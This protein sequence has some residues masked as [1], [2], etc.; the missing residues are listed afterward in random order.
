MVL[1]ADALNLLSQ[2][3]SRS[4]HWILTPHPGEAARLLN[5]SCSELQKDRRQAV[6]R[7]QQQYDGVVILK[8]A[9]TLIQSNDAPTRICSAG[10]PGM[11]SGGMGDVLSGVI[12][13]LLAQRL[14]L[15]KAAEVGVLIHSLAADR[16]AA[17][18][19]ERGLLATDL[20][21]HLRSL[22]NV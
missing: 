20:F 1:D 15:S 13:G 3:P 6:I 4:D 8:G 11:S 14:S 19:G 18:E 22:V 7:L 21:P 16:A 12:G 17:N 2:S 5:M 10:N 9:G